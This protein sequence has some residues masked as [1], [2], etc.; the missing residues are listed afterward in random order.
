M[1]QLKDQLL[2]I[3]EQ[4]DDKLLR[5]MLAISREYN[6]IETS[7]EESQ[8]Y[9]LV[10]T[11]A[12]SSRCS[13]EEIE[14]ILEASR[15]NNKRLNVTGIL[16]HTKDRFLQVLEGDREKVT[17]LY[18]KIEKDNRHGGSIMRF[19]EPV[20]KRYFADW[21]MASKKV[22]S[23]DIEYN[24][25]VSDQKRKL[26]QSMMDGDLSSYKDEGMRVLKTFLLIS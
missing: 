22:N 11:S 20:D 6:D 12:R 3:V 19:C 14:K 25:S 9:R 24:T 21:N 26:Y 13:D 1:S 10:Y 7:S 17:A 23:N 18:N 8:L 16:I 2:E 15:R 4:A 5:M